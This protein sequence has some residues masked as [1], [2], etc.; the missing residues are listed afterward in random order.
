MV[1]FFSAKSI[2]C[3]EKEK[4]LLALS[5]T[6]FLLISGCAGGPGSASRA[7]RIAYHQN[8]EKGYKKFITQNPN[9]PQVGEAKEKLARLLLEKNDRAALQ[10]FA[11]RFP[12]KASLVQGRLDEFALI[13]LVLER[14]NE[15][16]SLKEDNTRLSLR[17]GDSYHAYL[18]SKDYAGFIDQELEIKFYVKLDRI[19]AP[20]FI[21]VSIMPETFALAERFHSMTNIYYKITASSDAQP[22]EYPIN[23]LFA[24]YKE[25]EG[26]PKERVSGTSV[27]HLVKVSD[28]TT[29]T[30][31]KVE[32][33]ARCV[34]FYEEKAQKTQEMLSKLK[35]TE[36]EE[37][38]AGYL[39]RWKSSQY[40][41]EVKKYEH[42]RDVAL[43]ELKKAVSFHNP[44]VREKAEKVLAG[45]Q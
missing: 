7:Y 5:V 22:G 21:K 41:F 24:L 31:R 18:Y 26:E 34:T 38:A 16:E 12:D 42:F 43:K 23:I 44:A 13:D 40:E 6:A 37:F 36:L 32:V 14:T 10:N 25:T 30:L 8:T 17:Q 2:S 19:I 15:Q 1:K 11:L 39:F 3:L 45:L 35:E 33:A 20:K 9:D 4:T 27:K 28:E 29:D